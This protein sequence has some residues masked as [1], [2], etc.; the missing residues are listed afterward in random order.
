MNTVVPPKVQSPQ[1]TVESVRPEEKI[2]LKKPDSGPKKVL[3]GDVDP[4]QWEFIVNKLQADDPKRIAEAAKSINTV[5]ERIKTKGHGL[6]IIRDDM[7]GAD[8]KNT[9]EGLRDAGAH[10]VIVTKA[11]ITGDEVMGADK[12]VVRPVTEKNIGDLLGKVRELEG[13]RRQTN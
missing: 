1:S 2:Q 9:I 7:L 13:P 10:K 4:D 5:V 6:L 12:Y 8:P 11:R 3:V